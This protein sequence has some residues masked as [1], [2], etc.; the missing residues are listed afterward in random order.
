MRSNFNIDDPSTKEQLRRNCYKLPSGYFETLRDEV[1][2]RVSAESSE[3]V[4][5]WRVVA[6]Q[7]GLLSAFALIFL[8]AYS[9]INIIPTKE[10]ESLTLRELNAEVIDEGFLNSSFIDFYDGA[11][12]T[13]TTP[14]TLINHDELYSY[15][16]DNI[17]LISL[18]YLEEDN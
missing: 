12:D 14:I 8:F 16:S 13:L 9:I 7:L 6:P 15:I 1:S 17:D 3:K 2:D 5:L 11:L 10:V 18:S 4:G